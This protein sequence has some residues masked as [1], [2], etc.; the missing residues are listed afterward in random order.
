MKERNVQDCFIAQYF[1]VEK[2]NGG[3]PETW[4]RLKE[5]L[6]DNLQKRQA[7]HEGRLP[8]GFAFSL[9]EEDACRAVTPSVLEGLLGRFLGMYTKQKDYQYNILIFSLRMKLILAISLMDCMRIIAK[10]KK[11]N[12]ISKF[13]IS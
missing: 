11:E 2:G 10:V 6:M 7:G 4:E 8:G 3:R 1:S 13:E 5:V 12:C 9:R